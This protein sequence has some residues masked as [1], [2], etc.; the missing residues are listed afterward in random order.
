MTE[1]TVWA[2]QI[3]A[4][5]L[6]D[7]R[8]FVG[9]LWQARRE[10]DLDN[11]IRHAELA[12]DFGFSDR[13]IIDFLAMSFYDTRIKPLPENVPVAEITDLHNESLRFRPPNELPIT[14][15]GIYP[16]RLI[17]MSLAKT[18]VIANPILAIKILD[19]LNPD[20]LRTEVKENSKLPSDRL[21]FY[22]RLTKSLQEAMFWQ[23]LV[24]IGDLA[25]ESANSSEHQHWIVFRVAK[26]ALELNN[27]SWQRD[28]VS[29]PQSLKVT[30][31]GMHSRRKLTRALVIVRVPF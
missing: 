8:G 27:V 16:Y 24:E 9:A 12:I 13:Q 25:I 18:V 28:Y 11:A 31:I 29:I 30:T 3:E 6:I 22:L 20:A 7:I 1:L 4:R 19:T 26:A 2:S 5:R 23:R 15:Y 21:N 10:N 17:A 14:N